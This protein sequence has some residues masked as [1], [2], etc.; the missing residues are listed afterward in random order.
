MFRS[1]LYLRSLIALAAVHHPAATGDL[2]SWQI[3]LIGI[4]VPLALVVVGVLVR[5]ARRRGASSPA[6]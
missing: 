3:A 5:L 2:A 1:Y 4:G 6:G